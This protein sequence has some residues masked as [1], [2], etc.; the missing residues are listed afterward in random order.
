MKGLT[1]GLD[2]ITGRCVAADVSDRDKPEW[3]PHPG[4][5]FM[6]LAAACFETGEPPNQVAALQWLEGLPPP[7]ILASGCKLRSAV[8]YYVPVNDKMSDSKSIL[9]CTPGLTRSKQERSYPTAIP[10][11][12]QVRYVWRNVEVDARHLE[13]LANLCAEVIRVGHSSSL[14]RAWVEFS[15]VFTDP[16]K[17]AHAEWWHPTDEASSARFRV[18]GEGELD[19]LRTACNFDQIERFGDLKW[20]IDSTKGKE[21]NEAKLAFEKLVGQ[22]YKAALRVPEPSPAVLGLWQGYHRESKRKELVRSGEH[23]DSELVILSQSSEHQESRVLGSQDCLSLT[24]CLRK[25]VMSHLGDQPIPEWISGHDAEGNPS[26]V[27]HVA[28][29]AL[30]FVG[31]QYA[32]GHIMGLALALPKQIPAEERGVLLGRLLMDE[33]GEYRRIELKLGALGPWAL[34]LETRSDRPRSLQNRSWTGDHS[35]WASA[36]PV[37]LDK[38]PKASRSEDRIAWEQEVRSIISESCVRSGLPIPASV[39]IDTSSWLIGSPRAYPKSRRISRTRDHELRAAIGDGFPMMPTRSGKPSRPQIH[40]HLTFHERIRG[41]VLIGAGRFLG[42][43]L[44]KPFFP[45]I[46]ES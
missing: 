19:R 15:E 37:V 31:R 29:L 5:V 11:D 17:G 23:F 30:P 46:R 4:R 34:Q 40:V 1:V 43:G 36:T 16:S 9:Q 25:T 39:D 44:C 24:Q 6:A 10:D 13:S 27:P 42:Y 12:P 26:K 28:Y 38:F 33:T 32:D 14:V 41:P 7:S 8:K 3:P 45:R 2:F 18:V 22:P 35:V 21:R 20:I